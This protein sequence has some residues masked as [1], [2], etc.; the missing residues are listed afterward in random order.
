MSFPSGDSA[1]M[2]GLETRLDESRLSSSGGVPCIDEVEGALPGI[3]IG[4]VPACGVF[5]G[6]IIPKL[7]IEPRGVVENEL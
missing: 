2:L 3:D 4:G 7:D 6:G 5:V 1:D